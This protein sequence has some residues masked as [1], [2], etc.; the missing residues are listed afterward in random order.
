MLGIYINAKIKDKLDQ[1]ERKTKKWANSRTEIEKEKEK[2]KG[3]GKRSE[4]GK[5][6]LRTENQEKT[7]TVASPAE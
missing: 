2:R 4:S 3:E 5:K 6:S 1:V 7:D